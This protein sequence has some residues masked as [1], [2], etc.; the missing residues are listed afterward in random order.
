M[1]SI[2]TLALIKQQGDSIFS[3]LI[4]YEI[5]IHQVRNVFRIWLLFSV[6][7]Q[8][9]PHCTLLLKVHKELKTWIG[10]RF[11][12]SYKILFL[13]SLR[14]QFVLIA[15]STWTPLP[16]FYSPSFPSIWKA[17]ETLSLPWGIC[18]RLWRLME[19]THRGG[20]CFGRWARLY[21]RTQ[22]VCNF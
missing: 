10:Q 22:F 14:H 13:M 16:L 18:P 7:I 15:L 9:N 11:F 5:C 19:K 3:S 2:K 1:H 20:K 4:P 21:I 8:K 12:S 17:K 6:L